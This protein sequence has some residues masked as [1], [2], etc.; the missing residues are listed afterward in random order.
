MQP[1]PVEHLGIVSDRGL[2]V[3]VDHVKDLGEGRGR[4]TLLE[5][6]REVGWFAEQA[7]R[8]EHEVQSD[9]AIP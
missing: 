3:V 5:E 8:E 2:A 6:P 9:L 7:P 4:H 1:A